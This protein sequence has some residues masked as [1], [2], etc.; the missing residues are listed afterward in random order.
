MFKQSGFRLRYGLCSRQNQIVSR[1][2]MQSVYKE[3]G[4]E[5]GIVLPGNIVFV[6]MF[7]ERVHMS[8]TVKKLM[9]RMHISVFRGERRKGKCTDSVWQKMI[10]RMYS[11]P[12]VLWHN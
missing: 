10:G 3:F 7:S 2:C 5:Q 6:N 9:I 11:G 8:E 1:S 4:I 12:W